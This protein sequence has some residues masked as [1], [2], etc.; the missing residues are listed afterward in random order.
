[1]FL[2]SIA[3]TVFFR[4]KFR[5]AIRNGPGFTAQPGQMF[6]SEFQPKQRHRTTKRRMSQRAH[7]RVNE[8]K[9]P[10]DSD[11]CTCDR[12]AFR[13]HATKG[14]AT[15]S[16][17]RLLGQSCSSR[18]ALETRRLWRM[19]LQSS[20]GFRRRRV[21]C[22]WLKNSPCV[23]VWWFKLRISVFF[24]TTRNSIVDSSENCWSEH[25]NVKV[26]VHSFPLIPVRNSSA[27]D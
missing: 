13:T 19:V 17:S 2:S 20:S 6:E 15:L 23:D 21:L 12:I 9:A 7:W 10:A 5:Q 8:T 27:N 3:L 11:P 24:Q 16:C 26:S 18:P 14:S 22:Y 4:K 25:N 1:M